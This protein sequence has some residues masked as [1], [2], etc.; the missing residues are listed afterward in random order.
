[1]K[2]RL[3]IAMVAGL[4]AI[5]CASGTKQ[6]P[7]ITTDKPKPSED[8]DVKP[9]EPDAPV[10]QPSPNS[11]SP[12]L[13]ATDTDTS[14]QP[15]S[16][17]TEASEADFVFDL[18]RQLQKEPGNIFYSPF[19]ISVALS[20]TYAGARN[21]TER[22]MAGVL[23]FDAQ[24]AQHPKMSKTLSELNSI[25]KVKLFIANA[26]WPAIQYPFNQDFIKI[27]KTHYK[28]FVRNLDFARKTEK[29]RKIINTWVRRATKGNIENLIEPG[30]LD[31]LTRLVLTNAI[32]FKGK[33]EAPFNPDNTRPRPFNIAPEKTVKVPMM[34]QTGKFNYF[35]NDAIQAIAM[36]YAG[37]RL[38]MIAVL[39]KERDGLAKLEA[40][41]TTTAVQT[42]VE[43]MAMQDVMVL[44]PKFKVASSFEL[45][46]ALKTMGMT[47][48]FSNIADFSGMLDMTKA[49]KEEELYISKV[50]H[51]AV[52]EVNE[53]GTEAAAATA[54]VM[55]KYGGAAQFF[56]T[57]PFLFF[58][59]DTLTKEILFIGRMSDPN[60]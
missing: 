53:K 59:R 4:F 38:A 55:R 39:P 45:S 14:P 32:Y 48:A 7:E 44:F 40:E 11:A 58:I 27:E 20:M 41:V 37:D 15:S 60:A 17:Q 57:R 6:Q 22:Q 49:K 34:S 54:V 31:A 3:A 30:I 10:T 47:D 13:E 52:V 26:I 1:M 23:G 12:A 8:V 35:D 19:S 42:W 43:K 46:A 21:E 18:Y 24:E 50:V 29:S 9:P 28:S 51:K 36:P 5:G 56:A 25:K 33:W 16:P 2:K